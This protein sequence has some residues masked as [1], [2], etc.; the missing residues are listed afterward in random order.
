MSAIRK[1]MPEIDA[2]TDHIP[3][4]ILLDMKITMDDFLSAFSEIVPSTTR[5]VFIEV[6]NVSW[7][8]IG[9]LE[10]IKQELKKTV[11]WPLKYATLFKYAHTKPPTGVLLYGPPGTGKTLIAK[12]VASE[13]NAN[14]ISVK[15]PEL[16]SKWVG[17][18]ESGI[19]EVFKKARQA[20]PCIIFFDELDAIA[21]S[22]GSGGDT[23]VTERMVSQLLTE[24]DGIEELKGVTVLATT[25]RM[26]MIDSALLRPGRFD[27][28]MEV[29]LP[30]DKDLLAILKVHNKQRPLGKD[31]NFEKLLRHMKGFT[32]ADVSSISREASMIAIMEYIE[33]GGNIEK[34]DFKIRQK[35]FEQAIKDY[36]NT[37]GPDLSMVEAG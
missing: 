8:D 18:S 4:E 32:G 29:P 19:R 14:F 31:V 7:D 23:Q 27:L 11:E 15:G 26:D 5:E 25:N 35:H 33:T 10:N 28:L 24:M 22:R 21:P 1:I 20:S 37:R 12:A 30:E 9:G 34:P 36:M 3:T 6:P 2:E 17:E 16:M 13:S